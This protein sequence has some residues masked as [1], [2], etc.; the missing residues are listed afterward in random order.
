MEKQKIDKG[1][2]YF[3]NCE[4]AYFRSEEYF[5]R[6]NTQSVSVKENY[7][8]ITP[9]CPV[10]ICPYHGTLPTTYHTP[11]W[12]PPLQ[13]YLSLCPPSWEPPA[14]AYLP[15]LECCPHSK[16]HSFSA[17]MVLKLWSLE[18]QQ[19]CCMGFGL[20]EILILESHPR[21]TESESAF[22]YQESQET[23]IHIK[24]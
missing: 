17:P 10:G 14:D 2:A 13:P 20:L 11:K 6:F 21:P 12:A 4:S 23:P 18:P 3:E 8:Q 5:S 1:M 19:W 15:C 7:A 24:V 22:Y 16:V 9:L